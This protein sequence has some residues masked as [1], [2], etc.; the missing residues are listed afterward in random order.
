MSDAYMLY[1]LVIM[2]QYCNTLK[3]ANVYNDCQHFSL[4]LAGATFVG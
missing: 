2:I 3:G 4:H 1:A